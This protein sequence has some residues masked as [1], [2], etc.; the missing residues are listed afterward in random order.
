MP[1][2]VYQDNSLREKQVQNMKEMGIRRGTDCRAGYFIYSFGNGLSRHTGSH[3]ILNFSSRQEALYDGPKKPGKNDLP[4]MREGDLYGIRRELHGTPVLSE[5][6]ADMRRVPFRAGEDIASQGAGAGNIQD[7]AEIP[8]S[9]KNRLEKCRAGRRGGAGAEVS[10]DAHVL[11]RAPPGS[12][13]CLPRV[14][15]NGCRKVPDLA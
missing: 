5:V 13:G 15:R 4:E 11:Y 1:G 8:D 3:K 7:G 14:P 10:R 6:R 12:C 9:R 2:T